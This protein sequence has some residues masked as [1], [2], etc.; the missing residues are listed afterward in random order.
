MQPQMMAP[1]PQMMQA[2]PMMQPGMQPMQP[3]MQPMMQTQ[4][5]MQ[6]MYAQPMNGQYMPV[7]QPVVMVTGVMPTA[8]LSGPIVIRENHPVDME[9]YSCKHRGPTD[10]ELYNGG[11][12]WLAVGVLFMLGFCFLL[13]WFYCCV[14]CC[15]TDLK[16]STHRCHNCHTV[17]G[18]RKAL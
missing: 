16:D 15:I 4:P 3:G 1:Q 17:V 5:G 14:P 8:P 18:S 12:V 11:G 9:C 10:V 7:Q 2:Q 13:P 6:P